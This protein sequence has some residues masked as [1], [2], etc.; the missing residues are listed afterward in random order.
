MKRKKWPL[1][2]ISRSGV[3]RVRGRSQRRCQWAS[4]RLVVLGARV[5][6]LVGRRK[7]LPPRDVNDVDDIDV[8]V[9]RSRSFHSQESQA[10][11][12]G[13]RKKLP[14]RDVNDVDD[15][16]VA[17]P[18]SRSFR[19]QKS[20]TRVRSILSILSKKLPPRDVVDVVGDVD[21]A[22]R[23]I[24]ASTHLRPSPR[25]LSDLPVQLVQ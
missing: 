23:Q 15:V 12:A 8:A 6:H 10:H 4:A 14:P 21:V 20:Q 22:G 16:D 24:F 2:I 9:P 25:F 13:R 11:L 1:G 7:R 17:V 3:G 18:R 5:A 19:S